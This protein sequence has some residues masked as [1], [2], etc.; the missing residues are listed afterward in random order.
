MDA[1]AQNPLNLKQQGIIVY[2]HREDFIDPE[3]HKRANISD[4]YI[5]YRAGK[6]AVDQYKNSPFRAVETGAL[7][8][9]VPAALSVVAGTAEEGINNR[10]KGTLRFAKSFGILAVAAIAVSK[11]AHAVINAVPSLKNFREEHP[12]ATWL[13]I[14]AGAIFAGVKATDPIDNLIFNNS[15]GK[16][17]KQGASDLVE[18]AP[19]KFK[20]VADNVYS[21]VG[22]FFE[23][24]PWV[25][26]VGTLALVGGVIA[27]GISDIYKV[28]STQQEVK[29]RLET[30]R[31]E[32]QLEIAQNSSVERAEINIFNTSPSL[33]NETNKTTA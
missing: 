16:R 5:N 26:T 14:L 2:E 21:T 19:D 9:G 12:T 29:H 8:L 23:K 24:R 27:K 3:V 7:L 20:N 30:D 17:V 32:S 28:R 22:D 10:L 31:L 13:G 25:F 18:N 33:I 15:F 4:A 11:A 6:E 1:T